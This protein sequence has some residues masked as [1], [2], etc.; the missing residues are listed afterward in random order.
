MVANA[1]NPS[2]HSGGPGRQFSG[3]D[4]EFQDSQG[5]GKKNVLACAH[6]HTHAPIA[7]SMP[8]RGQL[9]RVSSFLPCESQGSN[10]CHQAS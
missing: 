1:F 7:P 2:T 10:S 9:V 3:L 4:K 8:I 6:G 5:S